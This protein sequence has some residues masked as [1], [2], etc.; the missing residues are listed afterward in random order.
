[1]R[2]TIKRAVSLKKE[3]DKELKKL[4]RSEKVSYSAILQ[5]AI[6]GYLKNKEMMAMEEA[7]AKYYGNPENIEKDREVMQDIQGM[8]K[9][10]WDE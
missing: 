1:M 5:K 10:V 4:C 9:V 6:D 3:Q 2:T 7:Y 8:S